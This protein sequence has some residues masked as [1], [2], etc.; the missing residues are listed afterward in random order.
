MI[1]HPFVSPFFGVSLM[2]AL[3]AETDLRFDAAIV[4]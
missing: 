2:F 3:E 1:A 4:G